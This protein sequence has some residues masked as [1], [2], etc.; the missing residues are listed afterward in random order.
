[1]LRFS[2]TM[3]RFCKTEDCPSSER[4]LSF[5]RAETDRADVEGIRRHLLLC[6]FCSAELEFYGLYPPV[7]ARTEVDKIPQPLF[8]LAEGLLRKKGDLSPLYR[9]IDEAD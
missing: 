7:A 9:L 8:Q 6:E 2:G 3:E 4:L 5:Q 1:M